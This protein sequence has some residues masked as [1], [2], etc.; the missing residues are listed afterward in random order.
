[1]QCSRR[2]ATALQHGLVLRPMRQEWQRPTAEVGLDN[3]AVAE[4]VR[5]ALPDTPVTGFEMVVGGLANTNVKVLIAG[6]P[7]RVLLRLYQRDLAQ[8]RKEAALHAL[9]RHRVPTARF[10]YFS[11]ANMV[12]GGPYA[13]LEWV[14]GERLE[15]VAPTLDRDDS[16]SL[17]LAVGSVLASVHSFDFEKFGFFGPDLRVPE[18][19]DLGGDGLLAYLRHCIVEGAGG[20]WLGTDLTRDLFTFVEREGHRLNAW[21]DRPCLVHADFNGSNVLVRR[22]HDMRRTWEVAAILDWEFAFSGSPAFDFGNL[23]R[24]P[25]GE[26]EA[27][28]AATADGYREAAKHPLPTDWRRIAQIADLFSWA[29]FLNRPNPGAAII[30]DARSVVTATI[31]G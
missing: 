20:Q 31:R 22:A 14:E 9:V 25:L 10:L 19:I 15:V 12:T 16:A 27:F 1:M 24:A 11:Q 7:H 18:A 26:N 8:A 29:N 3:D 23:L 4:L 6:P 13:I 17:G 28:S 5:P 30:E 21:L 2:L